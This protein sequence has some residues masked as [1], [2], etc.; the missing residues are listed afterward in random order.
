MKIPDIFFWSD[1]H[2]YHKN[3]IKYCDRPFDD[4]EHM[5]ESLIENFNG[6]VQPGDTTYWLG[7]SFFCG[8]GKA[9][10]I[11][12]RLNGTHIMIRGNHDPKPRTLY[13]LGFSAVM[14]KGEVLIGG[15]R[16][17][18]CHFPYRPVTKD[19]PE[20]IME[21]INEFLRQQKASGMDKSQKLDQQVREFFNEGKITNEQKKRLIAYDLRFSSRRF[22]DD[23]GWL[24]CGH[25]HEKW[26]QLGKMINVGV[27][28][29]DFKP[30][31]M[32]EVRLIMDKHND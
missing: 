28:V 22:D 20:D 17:K 21:E 12:E 14:E 7:D 15:K 25:V 2:F 10:L 23:G 32:E 29:R 30:I 26:S 8:T 11:M 13:K 19:L 31:S 9:M 4:L 1:P 24:L 5:H 16:V 6:V 27:D 3:V 18:L